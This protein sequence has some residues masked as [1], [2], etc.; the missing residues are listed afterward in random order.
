MYGKAPKFLVFQKD[1]AVMY[2]STLQESKGFL[3]LPAKVV[4]FM[5]LEKDSMAFDH[6]EILK[7]ALSLPTS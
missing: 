7:Y 1:L 5:I 3:N 2:L 6:Y 4:R